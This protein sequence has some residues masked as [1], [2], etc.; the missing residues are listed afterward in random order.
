VSRS[1]SVLHGGRISSLLA[2]ELDISLDDG[3]EEGGK[4]S[5]HSAF[6]VHSFKPAPETGV[7]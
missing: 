6:V 1:A 3:K 7:H 2:D 4:Y 5:P